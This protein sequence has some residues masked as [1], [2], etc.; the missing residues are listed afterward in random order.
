MTHTRTGTHTYTLT[1]T[2]QLLSV[3]LVVPMFLLKSH[4]VSVERNLC[5][6]VQFD[7]LTDSDAEEQPKT[8]VLTSLAT[9]TPDSVVSAYDPSPAYSVPA[10]LRRDR[11][12]FNITEADLVCTTKEECFRALLNKK[13]SPL[14]R[15][16]YI[17]SCVQ[18]R[19]APRLSEYLVR[20]YAYGV[21]HVFLWDN[22]E[23]F[24]DANVTEQLKDFPS[25]MLTIFDNSR[26]DFHQSP[27]KI[28]TF[29][30][31]CYERI[32]NLTE[33]V[34][35]WDDDIG[36]HMSQH[37]IHGLSEFLPHADLEKTCGFTLSWHNI[38]LPPKMYPSFEPWYRAYPEVCKSVGPNIL[39]HM[40]SANMIDQHS[41]DC[42]NASDGSKRSSVGPMHDPIVSPHKQD[43]T[44]IHYMY[45][46]LYELLT[47]K[48][49]AIGPWKKPFSVFVNTKYCHPNT[50][51][52]PKFDE[53]YLRLVESALFV[54]DPLLRFR[55]PWFLEDLSGGN[56]DFELFYF[57]M[58]KVSLEHD[59]C[60]D[61]YM[62][63]FPS[64][65]ENEDFAHGMH[66]FITE[67]F[68]NLGHRGCW[69]VA[70]EPLSNCHCHDGHG[71][72]L[73]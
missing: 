18:T 21:Q 32:S 9:V 39:A 58:G 54:L 40:P 49:Q 16:Y 17:S 73:H 43:I 33:W 27:E 1:H 71:D 30:R 68:L 59:W 63:L 2:L 14:G 25:E 13:E 51:Y 35:L 61:A 67:G 29:Y 34:T 44:L 46:S 66:H 10:Y 62:E 11:Y 6:D 12:I 64:V 47:K 52:V 5:L 28:Q 31:E 42:R 53:D 72:T 50:R 19:N 7:S 20:L 57:L 24:G 22:W 56:E 70:G 48:C 4:C 60:E 45:R 23:R 65:L 3:K 55:P 41:I 15:K 69:R 26:T 36:L 38:Y 37:G 8:E